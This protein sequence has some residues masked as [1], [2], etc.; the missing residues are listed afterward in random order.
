MNVIRIRF[1]WYSETL[2]TLVVWRREV[3]N[4]ILWAAAEIADVDERGA[5]GYA[6]IRT[7]GRLF[8]PW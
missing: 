1:T 7:W 6:L 4:A 8:D 3:I 5:L 2:E